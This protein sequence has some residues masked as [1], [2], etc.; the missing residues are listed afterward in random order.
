MAVLL[1][2]AV[3]QLRSG[4]GDSCSGRQAVFR[5]AD[6]CRDACWEQLHSGDW[7][8]VRKARLGWGTQKS[9]CRHVHATKSKSFIPNGFSVF[10]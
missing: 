1:Q 3:A 9:A 7:K 10:C 6:M 8:E 2:H 4:G 5:A